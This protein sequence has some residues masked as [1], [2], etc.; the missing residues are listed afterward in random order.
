MVRTKSLPVYIDTR[1]D[2]KHKVGRLE[3]SGRGQR[4]TKGEKRKEGD[5]LRVERDFGRDRLHG[6]RTVRQHRPTTP[7]PPLT[8]RTEM[9][10]LKPNTAYK[11]THRHQPDPACHN[12]TNLESL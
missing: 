4:G 7:S 8:I 6:H 9:W 1:Q 12:E 11:T 10:M 3:K 5:T 2:R